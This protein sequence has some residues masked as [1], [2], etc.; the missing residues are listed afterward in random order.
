MR[1]ADCQPRALTAQPSCFLS[2]IEPAAA[3]TSPTVQAYCAKT[4]GTGKHVADLIIGVVVHKTYHDGS[5]WMFMP[6]NQPSRRLW[7]TPEA[8]LRGRVTHFKLEPRSVA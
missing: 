6:W 4:D 2:K 1:A 7:P 5:G 3:P 8:A